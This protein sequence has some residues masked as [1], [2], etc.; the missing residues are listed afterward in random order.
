[1]DCRF[2]YTNAAR[3][4]FTRGQGKDWSSCEAFDK[5]FGFKRHR[6]DIP[7]CYTTDP[8]AE[9]MVR[10][11]IPLGFIQKVIVKHK[12]EAEGLK[13]SRI[14]LW[15]LTHPFL[16]PELIMNIGKIFLW[17]DAKNG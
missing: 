11:H 17:S 12:R 8:Q 14:S 2:Y 16:E 4:S 13:K 10:D 1:L 15:K 7:D 3:L 6:G 9:V 5:M